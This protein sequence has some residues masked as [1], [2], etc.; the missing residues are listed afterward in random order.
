MLDEDET[1]STGTDNDGDTL[2][3]EGYPDAD[4]D[5]IKDCLDAGTDTDGDTVTN[6][7]DR[8][9]DGDTAPD[10]KENW[11]G[12][13]ALDGC[14]DSTSDPAWLPDIDNNGWANV[15]DLALFKPSLGARLAGTTPKDHKFDIRFD[16]VPDG[17]VNI[18]DVSALKPYLGKRC[19]P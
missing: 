8:D 7:I 18:L 11:V 15:L 16:I 19:T 6:V 10:W 9:D 5:T 17:W 3:N 12:T 14:P 1:E 2:V 13:D 4:G